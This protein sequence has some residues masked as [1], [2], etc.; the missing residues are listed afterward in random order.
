MQNDNKTSINENIER[1]KRELRDENSKA[2]AKANSPKWSVAVK[3]YFL[4][5]LVIGV[6]SYFQGCGIGYHVGYKGEE[7]SLDA[8]RFGVFLAS[9]TIAPV[10]A[11]FAMLIV[12]KKGNNDVE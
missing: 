4:S 11:I 7:F 3:F 9:F 2:K 6:I 5:L 10:V 12:P 8:A 1:Y